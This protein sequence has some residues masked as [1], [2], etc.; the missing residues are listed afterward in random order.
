MY[1]PNPL[2]PAR[3]ILF[4]SRRSLSPELYFAMKIQYAAF[5]IKI[6][7][8]EKNGDGHVRVKFVLHKG[9]GM[10]Q[11]GQ[12]CANESV[13]FPTHIYLYI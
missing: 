12:V 10:L 5:A 13:C 9:G 6:N 3:E 11:G 1:V 4:Q 7:L 8:Q 2:M